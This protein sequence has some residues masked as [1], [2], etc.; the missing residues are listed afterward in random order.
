[1]IWAGAALTL[2]GAIAPV[3]GSPIE[4]VIVLVQENRSFDNLFAASVLTH[5]GPYPGA[6]TSQNAVVG[7]ATQKLRAVPFE[8]PA[9]PSHSHASLLREWDR[10]KMDGFAT[11]S[12][13]RFLGFPAP[14]LGFAY[15]YL[16]PAETTIYHLLAARYA[17]A[18]EN[19]AP[20][21]V[22]TFPSHYTLATA[23]SRVAGNPD[24]AI[25][26]CDAKPGT[27]VPLFGQGEEVVTPGVFPCFD[28]LTI[29]DL[30]DAHGISWKYYTGAYDDAS[31]PAV[32]IYEAFRKV[33]YGPD[34]ERNVITPSGTILS[35]IQNCRLPAVS[36][37]MPNRVSSDHAGSLSAAGPGWVGSIYLAVAQSQHAAPQCNYYKNSAM[38]LTW[39]DSGGWY[40]HVAPPPGPDGT[41]WGFRIPIV[42]ISAWARSGYDEHDP[43]AAPYVSHTRREST[44][45]T[46]F[47]EKNWGLGNMGQRDVT[48][49]DLSDMFD[50]ARAK[51]VPSFS[52]VSMEKL[53]RSTH[54]NLAIAK[55]D[56]RVVDDDR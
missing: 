38:I 2:L 6:D 13:R 48:D 53:I 31:D 50:Y 29:A 18:D 39:D 8:Y 46:K 42:A 41:T 7:S 49:D 10:G 27:T 55:R 5:G 44:S 21:L 23:Q 17:L 9:D 20:R 19:F 15:A 36:F 47:I 1:M 4:H 54:F 37:V 25:W 52:E 22:P 12:V 43:H 14:A 28:Q 11:D 16:P 30:L 51:P 34:W 40:D 35:D 26:G 3:A 56:D 32:N 33:R 45:I 24:D